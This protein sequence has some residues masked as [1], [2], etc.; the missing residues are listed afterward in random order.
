MRFPF[1][2]KKTSK[3]LY[4]I[5]FYNL[6]NLF[7][8]K[9]NVR[10]LDEDF[11]PDGYKN[12]TQ[13]KYRK[14][15]SGLA[16]TIFGIGQFANPYPPVI[17]GVAEVENRSVLK[18]LIE[19]EPL[20]DV[21]YDFVHYESPDERGIDTGLI[22]RKKYFKVLTSGA[23]PLIIS[24]PDGERDTTRDILYVCGLLN[25]EKIHLFVN[26]WP[27]RRE[28]VESTEYKRIAAA[29]V[30]KR[31][32]VAI[33]RDETDPKYIVM[34]DFNDDPSSSSIQSLLQNT[35]LHN[36]MESLHIPKSRGSASYKKTWSLFD[37]ILL[38]HRFYKYEKGS[39]SF[40]TANIFDQDFLKELKGKYKGNPFRTFVGRKYLGGYSD[41]FPVYIVLK[42]NK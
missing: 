12:W 8:P 25:G 7:D 6:E 26:H 24:N 9:N 17:V 3:H 39:H 34:G 31:K 41:H 37:Q 18:D 30:I 36:P 38:S 16:K 29:E 20:E 33:Q 10:T 14:K 28:G 40:D 15:L 23:I 21:D 1:F 42:L 4:T 2:K 13:K 27:S 5:A 35:G 32:M 19:T 22:Y 11:T